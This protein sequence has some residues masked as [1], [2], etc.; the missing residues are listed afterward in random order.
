MYNNVPASRLVPFG[1]LHV[2]KSI[3]LCQNNFLLTAYQPA[4]HSH[5]A[6]TPAVG[7]GGGWQQWGVTVVGEGW[8]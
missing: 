2:A 3:D 8:W 6:L 1:L 5:P 4:H 7:V